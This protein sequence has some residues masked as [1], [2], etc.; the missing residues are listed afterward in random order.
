[1]VIQYPGTGSKARVQG[2]GLGKE[3]GA[4]IRSQ[5]SKGQGHTQGQSA[6]ISGQESKVRVRVQGQG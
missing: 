5:E 6:K 2:K 4:G 3:S 1:M